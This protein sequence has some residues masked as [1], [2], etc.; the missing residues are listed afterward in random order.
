VLLR[1]AE[2]GWLAIGQPSH[3]WISGQLA[4][5]WG[6]ARFGTVEPFEEVCLASE[7]H[8]LGMGPWDAEPELN[9]ETGLPYAFTEMP[10][11]LHVQHWTDGPRRLAV[12]SRYAALLASMHGTRLQRRRDLDSLASA[13]ATAVRIYLSE[14]EEF[15]ARLI[16]S[17]RPDPAL[18]QRNHLLL[19]IWDFL[20]LALCLD[21][22]P[23]TAHEVP[24][25][26]APAELELGPRAEGTIA[27]EPWPFREQ[28]VS[29]RCD[30]RRLGDHYPDEPAMRAALADAPWE[31][32]AFDL[33][34]G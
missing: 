32:V 30:A 23:T 5:A 24:T 20:S 8:D 26:A 27:I 9:P 18:L 1:K 25:A 10:V 16:A 22:A 4:R 21:W 3:A 19:W 11:R 14:Q 2:A 7:Q 15:Q 17:L 12:Q 28:R 31:T 34:P 29:V 13:D 33:L 6:N